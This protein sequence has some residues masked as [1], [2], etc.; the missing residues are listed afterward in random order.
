MS[1]KQILF[2]LQAVNVPANVQHKPRAQEINELPDFLSV[3]ATL[4]GETTFVTY[5]PNVP[6]PDALSYPWIKT[7]PNGSPIGIYINYNGDWVSAVTPDA[8]IA[9]IESKDTLYIYEEQET[10]YVR[11]GELLIQWGKIKGGT[12]NLIHIMNLAE[13]YADSD[14]S[15]QITRE[16]PDSRGFRTDFATLAK[17]TKTFSVHS[18]DGSGGDNS[19]SWLAIGKGKAV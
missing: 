13:E 7:N 4:P 17:N 2:A 15:L 18:P 5:G 11:L 3:I 19:F 8:F 16:S 6:G 9:E 10:K 1:T 14:Y 12:G